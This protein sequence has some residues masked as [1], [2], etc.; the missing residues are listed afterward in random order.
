MYAWLIESSFYQINNWFSTSFSF[1]SL[2]ASNTLVGKKEQGFALLL[3]KSSDVSEAKREKRWCL[4]D[5]CPA[6]ACK[7][8]IKIT[9]PW[10]MLEVLVLTWSE[11][12]S[13][14]PKGEKD[15]LTSWKDVR[16]WYHC[17]TS[18]ETNRRF[19][20]QGLFFSTPEGGKAKAVICFKRAEMSEKIVKKAQI[21][22]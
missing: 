18:V 15:I 22:F 9:S 21:I 17:N 19:V 12:S 1:F 10:V 3:Q 11:G 8:S 2:F 5:G 6:F 4:F 16:L 13:L 7:A 20:S 14:P